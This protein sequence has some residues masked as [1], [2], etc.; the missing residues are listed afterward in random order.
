M[1]RN[2]VFLLLFIFFWG[3]LWDM[4]AYNYTTLYIFNDTELVWIHVF[5]LN[6]LYFS[7]TETFSNHLYTFDFKLLENTNLASITSIGSALGE[8]NVNSFCIVF[9]SWSLSSHNLKFQ[10][11]LWNKFSLTV[12]ARQWNGIRRNYEDDDIMQ[13]N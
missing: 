1:R 2:C 4:I 11:D 6:T 13:A 9:L 7:W 3:Y 8:I 10:S 12:G 5:V